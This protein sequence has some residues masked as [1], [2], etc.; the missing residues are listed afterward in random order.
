MK[1][2]MDVIATGDYLHNC[3]PDN[4]FEKVQSRHCIILTFIRAGSFYRHLQTE[5][6]NDYLKLQKYNCYLNMQSAANSRVIIYL[7]S[8]KI[9]RWSGGKILAYSN[10]RSTSL[11]GT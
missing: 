4:N 7:R 5:R 1:K 10:A 6:T 8:L 11:K 2:C 3:P 9:E